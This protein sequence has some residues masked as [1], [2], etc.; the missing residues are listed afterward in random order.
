MRGGGEGGCRG[1]RLHVPGVLYH[2]C[3]IP[4][5]ALCDVG[6]WKGVNVSLKVIC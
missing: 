4:K 2:S 6:E 5:I 1:S 3:V